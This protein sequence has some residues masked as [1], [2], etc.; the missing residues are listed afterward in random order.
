MAGCVCVGVCEGRL[1]DRQD[2]SERGNIQTGKWGG[3][4]PRLAYMH[5]GSHT[6]RKSGRHTGSQLVI[7]A[8]IHSYSQAYSHA[9]M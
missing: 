3:R 5:A 1:T 8:N 4:E 9:S 2:R 6:R 7:Q